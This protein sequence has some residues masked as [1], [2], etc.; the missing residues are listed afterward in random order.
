LGV[1]L[2]RFLETALIAC[3][4]DVEELILL[5]HPIPQSNQIIVV[6]LEGISG[7]VIGLE[8]ILVAELS[9]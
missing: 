5:D 1:L 7:R 6:S 8:E 3:Q 2:Q 4:N 9:Q